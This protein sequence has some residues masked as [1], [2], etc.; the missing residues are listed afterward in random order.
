MKKLSIVIVTFHSMNLIE[1]CIKSIFRNND[2]QPDELE[3]IVIDNS[4]MREG[5]RLKKFLSEN[6][7]EVVFIKNSNNGYGTANNIGIRRSTADVVAIMNPDILLITPVFK[8]ILDVFKK[9]STVAMVG[10]KQLGHLDFSFYLRPEFE[11]FILTSIAS[12]FFNRINYYNEK[13]MFMSGAF[14][15]FDKKKFEEIGFFD[16]NIF[17]YCEEPDVTRRFREKEYRTVFEKDIK[18][19]HLIDGREGMSD[20]AFKTSVISTEYYFRKFGLNFK[21]FLKQKIFSYKIKYLIHRVI[22][23]K[24]K[25][26]EAM[27]TLNRFKETLIQLG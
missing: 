19:R 14:L 10:G 5:E 9:D 15:F 17:L 3:I 11:F 22:G 1:G 21:F 23:Q 18:Y 25:S 20:F 8:K 24:K 12:V 4:D 6:Y 27:K 2:L 13:Y 26:I 16:E 7:N